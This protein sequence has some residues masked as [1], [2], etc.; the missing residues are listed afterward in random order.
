MS[1]IFPLYNSGKIIK[2]DRDFSKLWSQMHCHLI[3]GLQ[4]SCCGHG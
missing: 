2:I 3:Y 4:C 1:K